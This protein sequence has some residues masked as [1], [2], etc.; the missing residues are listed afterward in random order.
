MVTQITR[1]LFLVM[2]LLVSVAEAGEIFRASSGFSGTQGYRNWYYQDS[3]G[4][5]MSY[6]SAGNLWQGNETYLQ[7]FPTLMHPGN[8]TDAVRRWKAPSAGS[9]RITGNVYDVDTSCGQ[10]VSVSIRKNGSTLWSQTVANGNTAGFSFDLTQTAVSGDDI[11]FVVNRGVDNVWNCDTTFFDPTIDF[12]AESGPPP[13]TEAPPVYVQYHV[14]FL[15][16]NTCPSSN[17]AGLSGWYHWTWPTETHN[18]CNFIG[19]PWLRDISSVGYPMIGPY[20]SS[21]AEVMRWHIRLAK[22]AG[23]DG[24]FVTVFPGT[25]ITPA[26]QANFDIMLRVA[27]EENFKI[28]LEGWMPVAGQSSVDA[29]IAS[30]K[31]II[32]H[33]NASPYSSALVQI[34]NKPAYWFVYWNRFA[35][36]DD[37][38]TRLLNTRAMFWVMSG[39][40]VP[41]ELR[42]LRSR[43]TISEFTQPV[44]YN[45]PTTSGCSSAGYP[46]VQ[47]LQN[48]RADGFKAFSHG[49]PGFDER[50]LSNDST[51]VPFRYCN[52]DGGVPTAELL[53]ASTQGQADAV[54]LESWNDYAEYTQYEPGIDINQYRNFGQESIHFGDPYK[55]IRQVATWN[56]I[57]FQAPLLDC[58]IVDAPL[59]TNGVVSCD[60]TPPPTD[61]TGPVI[62][63]SAPTPGSTVQGQVDIIVTTTDDVSGSATIEIWINGTRRVTVLSASL[64]YRW[65]T[66]QDRRNF[67]TS[68]IE[69]KAIDN[70]GNL[71]VKTIQVHIRQ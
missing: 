8:F 30:V 1:T 52:R 9:V 68:T 46:I 50:R 66:N 58:A 54:L 35:S 4:N 59:R 41:D 38:A 29:W 7:I 39:P 67:P 15:G 18:P 45:Y 2:V 22:A 12:T 60:T 42:Y 23:I 24:F 64:T 20:K 61:T 19:A 13:P 10:G 14:W 37:L 51:R 11:D 36:L 53:N 70:A 27:S 57:A 17:P 5:L 63:I 65:N 71:S 43:L 32:D 25:S 28:G 31:Q 62:T 16:N 48:M 21:N 49:Y 34:N 33:A 3:S 6:N 40:L 56:G 44:E 26:L 69:V 55:Y 47:M